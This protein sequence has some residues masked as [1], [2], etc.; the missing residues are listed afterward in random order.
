MRH[1]WTI[2]K[3][4][5]ALRAR[6]RSIFIIG[7]VAPLASQIGRAPMGPP[8]RLLV[9]IRNPNMN[10]PDCREV[11]SSSSKRPRMRGNFTGAWM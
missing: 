10:Q 11:Y 2:A 3:N 7:L 6:D 1:A 5:L 9:S 4:D 8:Y